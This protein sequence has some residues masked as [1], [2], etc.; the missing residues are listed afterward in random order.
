MGSSVWESPGITYSWAPTTTI[1]I[2]VDR[3]FMNLS[4]SLQFGDLQI[5]NLSH[6]LRLIFWK[7][8]W[9]DLT[10]TVF[11]EWASTW[12]PRQ[13]FENVPIT[14]LWQEKFSNNSVL[15][16]FLL[17]PWGPSFQQCRTQRGSMELASKD[18]FIWGEGEK[19]HTLDGFLLLDYLHSFSGL[20]FPLQ[21]IYPTKSFRKYKNYNVVTFYFWSK[22]LY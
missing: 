2:H 5:A 12:I 19:T 9:K 4:C 6:R 22:W 21:F 11:W 1:I 10:S 15:I 16:F 13:N 7:L 14:H 20:I 18:I 8:N 17:L 3:S